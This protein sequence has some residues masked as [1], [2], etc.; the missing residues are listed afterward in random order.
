MAVIENFVLT[1]WSNH[2]ITAIGTHFLAQQGCKSF[3]LVVREISKQVLQENK[4]YQIFQKTN[5]FYLL[6]HIRVCV[7]QGVRNVSFLEYLMC[8][9][10]FNTH[11]EIRPFVLLSVTYGSFSS[12]SKL[13]FT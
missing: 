12:L 9:I 5:I 6:I 3:L 7:Y 13:C 4:A 2:T 8:F 10:F 1:F 11:F